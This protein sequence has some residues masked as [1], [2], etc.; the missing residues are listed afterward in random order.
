M[1]KITITEPPECPVC[2][3]R[4][5]APNVPCSDSCLDR[6]KEELGYRLWEQ[7]YMRDGMC[8]LCGNRGIVD[9]IGIATTPS[10]KPNGI[11]TYCICPNGQRMKQL[12]VEIPSR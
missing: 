9:T 7:N 3:D 5:Y 2:H 1:T 10:G 12:K 8:G 4:T 6:Y 11:R